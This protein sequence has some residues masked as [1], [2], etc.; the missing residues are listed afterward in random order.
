MSDR[1]NTITVVLENETRADDCEAILA[2]IRMVKGVIAVTPNVADPTDYM[3][4][5]RARRELGQKIWEVLYPKF[6]NAAP[7]ATTNTEVS[8]GS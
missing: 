1:I 7:S 5:E 4:Q 2:A 3:A 8:H 6:A